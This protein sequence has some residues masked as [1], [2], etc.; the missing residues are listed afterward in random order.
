MGHIRDRRLLPFIVGLKHF[1]QKDCDDD[2]DGDDDDDDIRDID[3][4]GKDKIDF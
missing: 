4:S 3:I 1:L 2:G